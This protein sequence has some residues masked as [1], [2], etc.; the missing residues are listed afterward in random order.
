MMDVEQQKRHTQIRIPAWYL[1]LL[2]IL[3]LLFP[4][5][6]LDHESIP[7]SKILE[8]PRERRLAGPLNPTDEHR[9]GHLLAVNQVRHLLVDPRSGRSAVIIQYQDPSVVPGLMR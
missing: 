4:I 9:S 5:R 3:L 7:N 6:A 1:I 2:L 8:M